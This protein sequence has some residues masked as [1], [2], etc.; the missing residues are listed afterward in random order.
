MCCCRFVGALLTTSSDFC[1]VLEDSESGRVCGY[2]AAACDARDFHRKAEMA[3]LPAMQ[4]KY[5]RPVVTGN[6][7]TPAQVG[8][9]SNKRT[10]SCSRA[11]TERVWLQEFINSAFYSHEAFAPDELVSRFPSLV[12]IDVLHDCCAIDPTA[13][14]RLVAATMMALR[15]H[16]SQGVHTRLDV[17][18]ST[19]ME[20]Y[21]QLHFFSVPLSDKPDDAVLFGRAI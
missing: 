9:L 5:P 19:S 3:W 21:S 11:L 17:G 8:S 16:G 1:F 15:A 14:R 12:R 18:D 7:L 10:A 6:E 4:E 20:R 2:A 13:F